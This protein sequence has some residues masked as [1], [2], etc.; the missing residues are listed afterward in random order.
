MRVF[1]NTWG[2]TGGVSSGKIIL[3][4][5]LAGVSRTGVRYVTIAGHRF[6]LRTTRYQ[7][8]LPHVALLLGHILQSFIQN[9]PIT[10]FIII[11]L[12]ITLQPV[13]QISNSNF[14]ALDS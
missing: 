4:D 1:T 7:K 14:T 12:Y 6:N 9:W 8:T 10:P 13:P 3:R 2:G 11:F 5:S